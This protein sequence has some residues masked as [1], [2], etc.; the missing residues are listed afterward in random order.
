M[1]LDSRIT[2]SMFSDL[3]FGTVMLFRGVA[4]V[5]DPHV[6]GID[7]GDPGGELT[8]VG[9]AD[10]IGDKPVHRERAQRERAEQDDAGMRAAW[11]FAQVGEF[12]IEG[13]QHAFFA[14]GRSCDFAVGAGKEIL[15]GC[16]QG[17]VSQSCQ[18]GISD[19]ARGSHPVSASFE[20]AR[21]PD[22]LMSKIGRM[23][24]SGVDVVFGQLRVVIQNVRLRHA[25]GQAVEDYGNFNAGVAD[26]GSP[27]AYVGLG[28]NPFCQLLFFYY[29]GPPVLAFLFSQH[30]LDR[31]FEHRDRFAQRVFRNIQRR[32]D[33]EGLPLPPTGAI[34]F[35]RILRLFDGRAPLDGSREFL[36]AVL[37]K[38]A[39]TASGTSISANQ[40]FG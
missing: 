38:E 16:R 19:A 33:L 30:L 39:S 25:L 35:C 6:C 10:E 17:I 18:G 34:G 9:E 2:S 27:A 22:T 40:S 1:H 31:L 11:I 15:I 4:R 3:Y 12:D 14:A 20:G 32:R 24:K 5:P 8:Q 29:L 28:S 23:G 21:S 7:D 36:Q 13:Q 26:A 37:S